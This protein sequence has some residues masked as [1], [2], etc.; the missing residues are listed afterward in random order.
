MTEKTYV[1]IT[2]APREYIHEDWGKFS[3]GASRVP[4]EYRHGAVGLIHPVIGEDFGKARGIP[5]SR[6]RYPD[7]SRGGGGRSLPEEGDVLLLLHGGPLAKLSYGHRGTP[8]GYFLAYFNPNEYTALRGKRLPA[9]Q[10]G[11]R[12][13][14]AEHDFLIPPLW[15]QRTGYQKEEALD[16]IVRQH[17]LML[18]ACN[19]T[20]E[21]ISRLPLETS[22]RPHYTDEEIQQLSAAA[23]E[24]ARQ[25]W[26]PRPPFSNKIYRGVT[27]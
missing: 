3:A 5:L 10:K 15:E 19:P 17:W 18:E 12:Q 4:Y 8:E 11:V 27:P 16:E 14:Y 9:V 21:N 1:V 6:R 2:N 24:T 7:C 20:T 25:L 22:S 23:Q 26:A 13:L